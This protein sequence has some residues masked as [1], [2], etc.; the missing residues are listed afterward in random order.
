[1]YMLQA[2]TKGKVCVHTLPRATAV[3]EPT[4][5]LREGF[6]VAT[7]PEAQDPLRHPGGSGAAT[8]PSAPDR[9]SPLRRGSTLMRI[10]RLRNAPP[11][12][13]ALVLTRVP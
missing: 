12:W 3:P 7:C 11:Q 1:M 6:G 13:W 8:C 9:T 10:I 5:L 2:R 4:S